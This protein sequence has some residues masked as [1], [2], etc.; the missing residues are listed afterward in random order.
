M[1]DSARNLRDNIAERSVLTALL[2]LFWSY[3]SLTRCSALHCERWPPIPA[4]GE[5]SVRP[6]DGVQR[7]F[8]DRLCH[9]G[10]PRKPSVPLLFRAISAGRDDCSRASFEAGMTAPS[11]AGPGRPPDCATRLHRRQRAWTR[12]RGG[13]FVARRAAASLPTPTA[14]PPPRAPSSPPTHPPLPRPR[15]TRSRRWPATAPPTR[16]CGRTRG[17]RPRPPP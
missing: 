9:T 16:R 10:Q 3:P 2:H 5:A 6:R 14:H 8:S 11:P 1:A 13:P 17:R 7:L 12:C 4:I 15:D